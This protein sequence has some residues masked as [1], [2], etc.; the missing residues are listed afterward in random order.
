MVLAAAEGRAGV[1]GGGHRDR[2]T[3]LAIPTFANGYEVTQLTGTQN[4]RLTQL[5]FRVNW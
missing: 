1:T 5:V 2:E 4:A 3:C